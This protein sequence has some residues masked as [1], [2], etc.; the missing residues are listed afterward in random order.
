MDGSNREIIEYDLLIKNGQIIDGTGKPSFLSDIGIKDGIIKK[1]GKIN[2]S[3]KKIID[4]KNLIISPGFVD[5]HTHYDG[6][7][8][9]D[10]Q[11]APSSLHGV[12]TV[13]MGNCGVG[14]APCKPQDREKLVELMEGVEDI[15]APVMHEGLKW[16][17][18]S[19]KESIVL[20]ANPS[21]NIED[22]IQAMK[23][24]FSCYKSSKTRK[25]ELVSS[26]QNET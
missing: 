25:N 13:V 4:A 22:A 21:G 9:W 7:A 15:P 20:G 11:L 1:I 2:E 23:V 3:A 16:E 17:W 24:V 19:F 8:I 18:E 12:S 6:Q 10:I 26:Y 5:I 14:F